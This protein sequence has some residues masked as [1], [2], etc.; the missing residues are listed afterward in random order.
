MKFLTYIIFYGL[1]LHRV[2]GISP[3]KPFQ[4][5]KQRIVHSS[6]SNLYKNMEDQN[7]DT[8]A[9]SPDLNKIYYRINP[10]FTLPMPVESVE[11]LETIQMADSNPLM[12]DRILEYAEKNHVY[13]SF[14]EVPTNPVYNRI[15]STLDF[16]SSL[17]YPVLLFFLARIILSGQ[18]PFGQNRGPGSPF[19]MFGPVGKQN[20]KEN[21]IK[22]NVSL[23]SWAGSPEVFNECVEIVSFLKNATQ[24]NN[25]GAELPK[26]ILLEGPPGTGKTLL[27]KAIA[28]EADANFISVSASEFIELYV[29]LGASKVRDLFRRAR[30]NTPAI[31]FI[32]EID[33][34]G[35]QRGGGFSMGGNDEREQT[36]N[37]ILAEMDG[38]ANNQGV[39]VIAATNRKDI[40]DSALLRPGR[41][42]RLVYVPLPDLPSRRAIL[43]VHTKNKYMKSGINYDYIAEA[44]GGFSGAQIKNLINEAA[45]FAARAGNQT[46]SQENIETAIEKTVI[47]IV[48]TNDTRT[49]DARRRVAIHEIGHAFLAHHFSKYFDLK[50]VTIQSTYEG[51]GGYTLFNDKPEIEESGLYTKEMLRQRLIV[52]LG[53]K[54]AEYLFYGQENVSLGAIQDLK[55][56]NGLAQR[57]VGN[58]GMGKELEIFFNENL[59]ST[60]FSNKYSEK[61]KAKFDEEV[62]DLVN[63]AY[64]EAVQIL[65]EHNEEVR[66]YADKLLLKTTLVATDFV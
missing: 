66:L 16:A 63:Q 32:D 34:V 55:Q 21:M 33:T 25:V 37:Q 7:V 54:A 40:L 65:Q 58:Y 36:L 18:T 45:I 56:A 42:D 64:Q 35:K 50:K 29:G 28:S 57:M 53:G 22:A 61:T 9:I 44:T 6:L 23:S 5:N 52:T 39:I 38:F 1:G 47:G 31:I 15:S 59:D 60:G 4:F 41:F 30:E 8:I 3:P 13:T 43:D 62:A 14:L 12:T 11:N 26:G 10:E 46:I 51:A 17:F 49:E 27:A 48:R 20:E 19:S 24:Y 2:H